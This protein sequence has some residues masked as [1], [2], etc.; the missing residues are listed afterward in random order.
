MVSQ[1]RQRTAILLLQLQTIKHRKRAIYI[2]LTE[3]YF[4]TVRQVIINVV[5]LH[6]KRLA[7][8]LKKFI[9]TVICRGSQHVYITTSNG[10]VA[11]SV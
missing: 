10:R 6:M 11:R 7:T 3:A 1:C 5:Y 4:T 8:T 2:R 9:F